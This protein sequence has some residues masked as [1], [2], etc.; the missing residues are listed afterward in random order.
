MNKQTHYDYPQY[1][2]WDPE[3]KKMVYDGFIVF[4]DVGIPQR[5]SYYNKEIQE[6]LIELLGMGDYGIIDYQDYYCESWSIMYCTGC[7]DKKGEFI[8]DG[9]IVSG[10]KGTMIIE[11]GDE[12]GSFVEGFVWRN[13]DNRGNTESITGFLDEYEVVGN[14]YEHNYYIK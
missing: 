7:T 14:I 1:R 4:P 12:V 8:Y 3:N 5:I 6:K 13:V 2:A 10:Y 11:R 9:D